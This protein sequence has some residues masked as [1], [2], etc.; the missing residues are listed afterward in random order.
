MNKY[1]YSL[2][3]ALIPDDEE[4]KRIDKMISFCKRAKIDDVMF[5]IDAEEYNDGHTTK[6]RA[7]PYIDLI[8]RAKEKLT[9]IGVTVSLNPWC[10]IG[11]GDRGRK[12]D[13]YLTMVDWSGR[14]STVC[15][16][17]TDK[18]WLDDLISYYNYLIQSI[19]PNTVWIEDDFRLHNHAP[20]LYGGCF[21]DAHMKLYNEQAGTNYS[22]EEFI[23]KVLQK[24]E[25]TKERAV[26]L[27]VNRDIFNDVSE[28]IGRGVADKDVRIGLMTSCPSNYYAE[29]RDLRTVLNNLTRNRYSAQR[30]HLPAYAQTTPQAYWW[31][32]ALDSRQTAYFTNKDAFIMP[33]LENYPHCMMK[34]VSFSIFQVETTVALCAKGI[35]MNIFDF[36]G[37]GVID[38]GIGKALR[39]IKPYLQTVTELS[40]GDYRRNGV[41]I[42]VDIDS[43]AHIRSD[44]TV[45][46]LYP[47]NNWFAGYL[48]MLGIPFYYCENVQSLKGETI[49]VSNQFLRNLSDAE[50][51]ETFGNNHIVMDA[52]SVEILI[53]RNLGYLVGAKSCRVIPM[54]CG[55]IS[56]EKYESKGR[57]LGDFD[58]FRA[59]SESCCGDFGCIEYEDSSDVEA[60]SNEYNFNCEYVCRG[61][62]QYKKKGE[63][64]KT[65][66]PFINEDYRSGLFAPMR[67]EMMR[68][69]AK[70]LGIDVISF[71]NGISVDCFEKDGQRV[72]I[73]TNFVSDDISEW[74]FYCKNDVKK[75]QFVDRNT[76]KIKNM[77][78]RSNNRMISLK[79]TIP[80]MTTLTLIIKE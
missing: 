27:K 24:G 67:R 60:I 41:V 68:K 35:T 29:G 1:E 4:D 63:T 19:H 50:I 15:A 17:P 46:S 47:H 8:N 73:F 57:L 52:T 10:S 37:N 49:A 3:F 7:K 12:T 18:K 76:G 66:F 48:N 71:T 54:Q 26:F 61:V 80:A 34:S 77:P 42:P 44:G 39:K 36:F 53:S 64:V 22:R 51:I 13:R 28:K 56:I 32:F 20:L 40:L 65:V 23:E 55:E 31:Y 11:H 38:N 21:C 45:E 30:V 69:I 2:R 25:P 5:F 62:T 70:G 78:F 79:T 74:K 58:D 9:E 75:I 72:L 43:S 14:K 59:G 16:C 6:E 33:E